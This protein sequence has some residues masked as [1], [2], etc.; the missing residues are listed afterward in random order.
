MPIFNSI[1]IKFEEFFRNLSPQVWSIL[2]SISLLSALVL[3]WISIR[4]PSK[5]G[6]IIKNFFLFYIAVIILIFAI[7]GTVFVASFS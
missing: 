7:I 5:G 6:P 4:N 2:I 1:Y 3:F